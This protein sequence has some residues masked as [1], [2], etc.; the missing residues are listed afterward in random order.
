MVVVLMAGNTYHI[1][2]PEEVQRQ[3]EKYG[4]DVPLLFVH[5]VNAEIHLRAV[6]HAPWNKGMMGITEVPQEIQR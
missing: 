2:V 5:A 4:I 3:I 6:N 1:Y